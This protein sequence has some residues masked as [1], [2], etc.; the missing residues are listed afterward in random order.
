MRV[1]V[2]WLRGYGAIDKVNFMMDLRDFPFER[3]M[4]PD[5]PERLK[6]EKFAAEVVKQVLSREYGHTPEVEA[7]RGEDRT[8]PPIESSHWR[9]THAS[10]GPNETD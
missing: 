8:I 9:K 1:F 10:K 4:D 7:L 2:K 6:I 5:D 3:P